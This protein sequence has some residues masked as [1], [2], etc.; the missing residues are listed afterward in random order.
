MLPAEIKDWQ[1]ISEQLRETVKYSMTLS[2]STGLK[3]INNYYYNIL[4]PSL[5]KYSIAACSYA[6][7]RDKSN[8]RVEN[9][10]LI[11]INELKKEFGEFV[12]FIITSSFR[13]GLNLIDESDIDIS[14][15]VDS[16]N[17]DKLQMIS[18]RLIKLG[19]KYTYI[20]N[21]NEPRSLY[22]AFSK[23]VD[24]IEIEVKVR[25]MINSSAIIKLHK[26]L[27]SQITILEKALLTYGKLKLKALSKL[28]DD[29]LGYKCLKKIIYEAYFFYIKEGF[30]LQLI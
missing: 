10:S 30:M 16:L 11:A 5:D 7:L 2:H 15:T 14:A 27:D 19:Y 23:W 3:Y 9:V 12:E 26:Y 22:Y 17:D 1:V 25:D 8:A 13:S 24:G 29:N 20:I 18:Q 21:A 4:L 6:E 28:G